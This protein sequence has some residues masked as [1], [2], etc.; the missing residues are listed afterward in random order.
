MDYIKWT[1]QFSV[2]IESIDQDHQQLVAML[3]ELHSAIQQ[4]RGDALLCQMIEDLNKYA[5]RHFAHEE[6]LMKECGY[7]QC[8]EH[9]YRHDEFREELHDLSYNDNTMKTFLT[10]ELLE[11]LKDWVKDHIFREDLKMAKYLLTHVDATKLVF[12]ES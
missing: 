3:N 4:G 12:H 2:G 11:F 8:Q 7:P 1:S 5:L 6:M 10:I 9:K